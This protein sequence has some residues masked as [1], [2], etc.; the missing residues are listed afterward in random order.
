MQDLLSLSVGQKILGF[1]SLG[2]VNQAGSSGVA[3]CTGFLGVD[4]QA[5]S[6]GVVDCTGFLG[7]VSQAGSSGIADSTGF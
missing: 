2:I 4:N 1:V 3:D 7:I 6:S 5:G